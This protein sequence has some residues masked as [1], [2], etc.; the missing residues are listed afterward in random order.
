MLAGIP[1]GPGMI[2]F[3]LTNA[4]AG[5]LG[6]TGGDIL[7]AGGLVVHGFASLG[8]TPNDDLDALDVG[9]QAVPE[10]SS[11]LLAALG[12]LSLFARRR[13]VAR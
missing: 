3:S 12:S 8:L 5:L 7:T 4:T 11:A 13:R 9:A 10:P 1:I 6:V 2:E